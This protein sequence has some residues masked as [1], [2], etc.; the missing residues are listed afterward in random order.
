MD[1]RLLAAIRSPQISAYDPIKEISRN[2]KAPGLYIQGQI[3]F[4]F[5]LNSTSQ[6]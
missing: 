5:L 2:E 1:R 3:K 4:K 6:I